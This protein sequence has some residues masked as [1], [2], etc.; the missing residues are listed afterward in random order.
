MRAMI[1]EDS[2]N[3]RYLY[4]EIL[5]P[6]ECD[7][8]SEMTSTD[9]VLRM[10][11]DLKPDLLI[12]EHDMKPVSGLETAR[13]ILEYNPAAS[14]LLTAG[15]GTPSNGHDGRSGIIQVL[16]KPFNIDVLI[17]WVQLMKQREKDSSLP[18]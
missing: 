10:Y 17:E 1:V 8:V 2:T 11:F 12:I 14:I 6:L 4:K 18:K 3:I 7:I 9:E 5:N 16:N 15:D 13:K